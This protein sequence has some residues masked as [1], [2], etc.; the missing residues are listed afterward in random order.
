MI[1]DG[2]IKLQNY[3]FIIRYNETNL[4]VMRPQ[5]NKFYINK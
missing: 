2:S 1:L 4:G 3:F 5:Q